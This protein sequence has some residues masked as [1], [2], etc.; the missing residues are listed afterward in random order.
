M[1]QSKFSAVVLAV[2]LAV[3][4]GFVSTSAVAAEQK[5][6]APS[7]SKPAAKPLQAAQ[8]AVQAKNWDEALAKLAEAEALP[9]KNAFDEYVIAQFKGMVLAQKGD[10]AGALGAFEAQFNSEFSAAEEKNRLLKILAQL[11]YQQK[12]Y[13]KAADFGMRLVNAG[14]A[15]ADTNTLVA[16]AYFLQDDFPKVIEF[17]SAYIKDVEAKGQTP[18]EANLQL[19]SEA[20][21]RTNNLQGQ[22]ALMEKL[23]VH[24]PK[25]NYWRNVLVMARDF[26][27]SDKNSDLVTLNIY[28][29]MRETATLR[30]AND[31]LELATLA[32]QQGSPGEAADAIRRGNGANIFARES[33]K[34][35]AKD[36]LATAQKLETDDRAGLARFETEA[37]AAK[38]GEGDVRLGQALLSYGQ[39]EKALEAIQRGIGKGGL[40]NAD[41][42][43]IF[44]GLAF[45]RLDRR[46]EAVAAFK[47]A[48][49]KDAK[50]SNLARLWAIHA[51]H[52]DE[53]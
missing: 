32:V 26:V 15:D 30:E 21:G 48:P 24:Y 17:L 8:A 34:A 27:G 10:Y 36:R 18:A 39:P 29:L 49:G 12:N 52:K 2:A 40:R 14:V 31:Y 23:V 11:N 45:L 1:S 22:Q 47:A 44:L 5:K 37:K 9:K 13:A 16:Q 42:A 38:A 7:V 6:A 35:S 19:L 51:S 43:Q 41:E 53:G 4:A 20:Y 46:D 50:I 33:E 25:P 28:R 3:G